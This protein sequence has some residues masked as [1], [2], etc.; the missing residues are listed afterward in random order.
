MGFWSGDKN[1]V[2]YN[3]FCNSTESELYF[4]SNDN[5]IQQ[6]DF[7]ESLNDTELTDNGERNIFTQNHYNNWITPD[8]DDNQIVDTAF[9]VPGEAYNQDTS[10]MVNPLSHILL[11]PFLISPSGGELFSEEIYIQWEPSIDTFGYEVSYTLFYSSDYGNSWNLIIAQLTPNKFLW[12]ISLLN[13]AENYLIKVLAV[14]SNGLTYEIILDR[15]FTIENHILS[16]LSLLYP[17][18]GDKLNDSTKIMWVAVNDTLGHNI[19]YSVFFSEDSGKSWTLI[20]QELVQTSYQWNTNTV[21]DGT[22]YRIM[23]IAQCNEGKS[24]TFIQRGDFQVQNGPE[25]PVNLQTTIL[26]IIIVTVIATIGISIGIYRSK[27]DVSTPSG[28]DDFRLG[29][30]FGTFSTAG[31]KIIGKNENCLFEELKLRSLIEF[32]AVSYKHG[33]YGNI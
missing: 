2:I 15:P 5:I 3:V 11:P 25:S 26:I 29:I 31:W 32:S 9:L 12:N 30:C 8:E 18:V 16:S 10:P 23:L 6:N 14:S 21:E 28:F 22:R 17:K 4:E 33:E 19:T 20:A 1:K 13:N 27:L 24:I 7:Y